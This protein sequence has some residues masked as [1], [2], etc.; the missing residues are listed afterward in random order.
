MVAEA[1]DV[2]EAPKNRY[3]QLENRI[4]LFILSKISHLGSLLILLILDE[5]ETLLKQTDNESMSKRVSDSYSD[6]K[7]N[8]PGRSGIV[9]VQLY[10]DRI[11]L[12][13]VSESM[14]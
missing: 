9:L 4:S 1:P 13:C 7:D 10:V 3:E 12:C 11:R 5:L 8:N 14:A 6:G 2:R